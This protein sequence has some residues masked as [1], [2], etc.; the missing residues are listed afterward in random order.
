M[1]VNG[2]KEDLMEKEDRYFPMVI[3]MREIFK[4]DISMEWEFLSGMMVVFI[5]DNFVWVICGDKE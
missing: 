2:Y 1:K 3:N 4:M 5:K